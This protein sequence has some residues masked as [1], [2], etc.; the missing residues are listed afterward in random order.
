MVNTDQFERLELVTTDSP[1]KKY[2]VCFINK[3]IW[4]KSFGSNI[5]TEWRDAKTSVYESTDYCAARKVYDTI[6]YHM[7]KKD[8]DYLHLVYMEPAKLI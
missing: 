5:C 4:H 2:S 8:L 6:Q 3:V 7:V 1:V